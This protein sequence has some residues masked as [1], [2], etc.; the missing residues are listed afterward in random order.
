[1]VNPFTAG[2]KVKKIQQDVLRPLY[3]MHSGQDTAQH[4]WLLVETGRA[5]SDHQLFI[6]EMCRSQL[7]TVIFKI[8]KF[9]GGADQLTEEDFV[10]FTAYVNDGGI[11]AM[12]QMLLSAD[13]EKTFV[14]ELKKLPFHVRENASPMLAKSKSLHSDFI[15]GFFKEMH[16]SVEKTPQKLRNNFSESDV[17]IH[18]LALLA[19]DN[20]ERMR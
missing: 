14:D 18:K 15:I 13:K 4:S 19:A 6:E 3:T 2:S 7:V 12:V 11:K 20:Q 17:F 16:G 8:I 10:R 5:I 9:L 1:M